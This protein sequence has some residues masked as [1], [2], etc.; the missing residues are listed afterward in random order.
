MRRKYNSFENT[1]SC[2]QQ[3]NVF[4]LRILEVCAPNVYSVKKYQTGIE[5]KLHNIDKNIS[6][7]T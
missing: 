5:F 4:V 1:M 6:F 3:V 7:H 2:L